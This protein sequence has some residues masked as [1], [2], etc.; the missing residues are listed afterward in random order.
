MDIDA[1]KAT[2]PSGGKSELTKLERKRNQVI[3]VPTYPD[4]NVAPGM[5]VNKREY[6]ADLEKGYDANKPLEFDLQFTPLGRDCVIK[7]IKEEYQTAS[8]IFLPASQND[9]VSKAI[10]LATGPH[11]H[12]VREGDFV[13]I[14]A[15][16]K[17]Q[18]FKTRDVIFH[19]LDESDA[20]GLFGNVDLIKREKEHGS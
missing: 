19:L 13:M 12:Y 2:Q 1:L 4:E 8:G 17:L 10:V 3:G 9:S 6:I 7:M 5:D 11:V 20:V 14:R 18:G 15:G 16:I